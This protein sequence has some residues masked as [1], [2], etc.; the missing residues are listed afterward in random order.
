MLY[1]KYPPSHS[2]MSEEENNISSEQIKKVA[3]KIKQ[4]RKDKGYTS[5]QDFAY[6]HELN[7]V[8]YWRVE[9]GHNI[10]LKTLFKILKI[11]NLTPEEFFK[12]FS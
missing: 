9:S 6:E 7:R 5:F 3:K 2:E 1:T 10:T 12:D 11:H 4:L 8:Q